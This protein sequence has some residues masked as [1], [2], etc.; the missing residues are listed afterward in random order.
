MPRQYAAALFTY[1]PISPI[2]VCPFLWYDKYA[3]N[4]RVSLYK[5]KELLFV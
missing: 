1:H 4:K 2:Y 5:R 3:E